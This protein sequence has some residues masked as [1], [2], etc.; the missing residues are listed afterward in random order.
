MT[1]RIA[2]LNIHHGESKAADALGARLV[3][4]DTIW[5]QSRG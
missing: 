5:R 3:E 4:Y 2:T 1:V